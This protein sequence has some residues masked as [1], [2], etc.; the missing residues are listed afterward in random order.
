MRTLNCIEEKD[1]ANE[2][3]LLAELLIDHF[4]LTVKLL[5]RQW[6]KNEWRHNYTLLFSKN[7]LRNLLDG[8]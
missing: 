4:K 5:I 1:L 6:M 3:L 7:H 2:E 8:N